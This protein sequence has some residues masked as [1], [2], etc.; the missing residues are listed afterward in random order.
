MVNGWSS[1]EGWTI[2]QE[3]KLGLS[4]T[5]KARM[6]ALLFSTKTCE[7]IMEEWPFCVWPTISLNLTAI[8]MRLMNRSTLPDVCQH[9]IRFSAPLTQTRKRCVPFWTNVKKF[10]YWHNSIIPSGGNTPQ[11]C[12]L[13]AL[14]NYRWYQIMDSLVSRKKINSQKKE[15]KC[16][17]MQMASNQKD[18]EPWGWST[19]SLYSNIKSLLFIH[20]KQK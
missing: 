16:Q 19:M 6:R 14:K 8:D 12:F 5:H 10:Y 17:D 1:P 13:K 2:S 3:N 7:S 9:Y 18:Q 4:H 11:V 20:P 15:T